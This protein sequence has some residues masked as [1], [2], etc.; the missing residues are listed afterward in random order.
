MSRD[1]IDVQKSNVL[2]LECYR[3][4]AVTCFEL[5]A[6]SVQVFTDA[7]ITNLMTAGEIF[8]RNKIVGGPMRAIGAEMPSIGA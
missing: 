5:G 4:S 1:L 2:L 7:F 6:I 3:H 8:G